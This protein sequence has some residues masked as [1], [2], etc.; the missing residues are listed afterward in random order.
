MHSAQGHSRSAVE[1]GAMYSPYKSSR[2]SQAVGLL[3]IHDTEVQRQGRNEMDLFSSHYA[4]MHNSLHFSA[5]LL[6]LNAPLALFLVWYFIYI[7]VDQFAI[8]K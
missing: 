4:G 2:D 6:N 5:Q 8:Y 7:S 3:H 1:P